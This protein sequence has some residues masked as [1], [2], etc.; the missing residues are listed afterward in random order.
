[1][2]KNQRAFSVLPNTWEALTACQM[3]VIPRRTKWPT[4]PTTLKRARTGKQD[5]F[6]VDVPEVSKLGLK[7]DLVLLAHKFDKRWLDNTSSE[8]SLLNNEDE[9]LLTQMLHDVMPNM[10]NTIIRANS[11]L[12][13]FETTGR[14]ADPRLE[15]IFRDD[16][17]DNVFVTDY[18]MRQMIDGKLTAEDW[19]YPVE[20]RRNS[21]PWYEL[22]PPRL[23]RKEILDFCQ[24]T[25]AFFKFD[26][27]AGIACTVGGLEF[28]DP[29]TRLWSRE[30]VDLQ[31]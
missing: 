30:E 22:S 21:S 4:L 9:M 7:N 18:V 28:L 8:D 1:M 15:L 31:P 2:S 13:L 6:R 29:W 25:Y 23:T 5:G 19:F 12:G 17:E 24:G 26:F 16:C 10:V 3:S 27:R 20:Q 11:R 14:F